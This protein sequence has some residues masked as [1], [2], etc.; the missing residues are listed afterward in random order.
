MSDSGLTDFV[1]QLIEGGKGE[2]LRI[3]AILRS[4]VPIHDLEGVISSSFCLPSVTKGKLNCSCVSEFSCSLL[5][6]VGLKKEG[7]TLYGHTVPGILLTFVVNK[8]ICCVTLAFICISR[9]WCC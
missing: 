1:S 6:P 4:L 8:V 3:R 2:A 5:L 9:W 7:D